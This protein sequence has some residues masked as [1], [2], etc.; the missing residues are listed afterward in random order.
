MK[1]P[2][3][4]DY[5]FLSLLWLPTNLFWSAMLVQL[6]PARVAHFAPSELQKG[7]YL[8]WVGAIGAVIS[9]IIQLLIGP[10][11]DNC[12]SRL[13]RRRPF[14]L[15]GIILNTFALIGFGL[16]RSFAGL[17]LSFSMIQLL[18]NTAAGP[19][20]AL[21]PDRVPPERHGLASAYMGLWT[22]LG[23][24]GGLALGGVLLA[25]STWGGGLTQMQA[26]VRGVEAVL[27]ISATL[28]LAIMALTVW[29][30]KE[31]PMPRSEALPLK[32]A[33]RDTYHL[34][35]RQYPDF[36]WLLASRFVINL[37]FYTAIEF[38]R[39]YVQDSLH[40]K[41]YSIQTT[42]LSLMATAG[43]VVGTFPAGYLADRISKRKVVYISCTIAALGC[44]AFCLTHSLPVAKAIAFFFGIG[45]GTFCAVD[46]AFA[47]NLLPE[48]SA[49][50]YMAIF[51]FSFTVP[52]VIVPVIGGL[53]GDAINRKYGLGAGWRAVFWT[54]VFYA[55]VGTLLISKVRERKEI[56][57][58]EAVGSPPASSQPG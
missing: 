52:Q 3:V 38:L 23:Q 1:E 22:L 46:W 19:F 35:L 44:A 10:L 9:T 48:K 58:Q 21:I 4:R 31:T 43:A 29:Q 32:A 17:V 39:Y 8:A 49:A 47:C 16:A 54:T 34:G 53:I 11:S 7:T 12:T 51:H 13:G 6:L 26:E 25:P 24:T 28:L 14:L 42:W 36:S 55:I 5:V 40:A 33:L 20:Q 57:A 37:G 15:I 2:R 56:E 45:Y 27:G 41:D 50:K 30:V 18:I